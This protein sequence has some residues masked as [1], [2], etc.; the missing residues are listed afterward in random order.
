MGLKS[1]AEILADLR[2]NIEKNAQSDRACS[3]GEPAAWQ[4]RFCFAC[5]EVR[6]NVARIAQALTSVPSRFDWAIF[7]PE[8][9]EMEARTPPKARALARAAFGESRVILRGPTGVGKTTLA[10]AMLRA[11]VDMRDDRV[12]FASA[13]SLAQARI[14]P[15]A[16]SGELVRRA[17][18]TG[19]LLLDDL[20]NPP[21]E[22]PS[23]PIADIICERADWMRPLWVTTYLDGKAIA[24]R[25]GGNVAR[26]LYEQA[27]VIDCAA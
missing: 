5:Q 16:E 7:E 12:L 26:L 6:R 18:T 27:I 13:R 23:S 14:A 25:Y 1:I 10:V 3:C 8:N 17:M 9:A 19:L 15:S 11:R 21:S 24:D 2:V 4:S 22:P 20:G